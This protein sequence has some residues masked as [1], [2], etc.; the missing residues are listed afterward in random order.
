MDARVDELQ[1]ILLTA[2]K[3]GLEEGFKLYYGIYRGQV[4]DNRDPQDMGRVQVRVDDLGQ[5]DAS[6]VWLW[7]L[8]PLAGSGKGSFFPPDLGDW[9]FVVFSQGNQSQPFAYFGGWFG[10]GEL[11]TAL[12]PGE[13]HTPYRRGFVSRFG[14]GFVFSDEPDNEYVRLTWN[15]PGASDPA[16]EDRTLS[17]VEGEGKTS[18][19]EFTKD[20]G[21]QIVVDSGG[22]VF[23]YT[24]A[25]DGEKARFLLWE[26]AN[27]NMLEMNEDGISMFDKAGNN[28]NLSKGKFTVVAEK[29]IS[30]SGKSVNFACSGVGLGFPAPM[31][32][33]LGEPL[34]AWLATHTH[35]TAVG[36]SLPPTI[37]P[38]P[39]LL[40]QSVK[41]KP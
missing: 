10:E 27:G 39:T 3:H 38:T 26:T 4:T 7:P 19:L 25:K 13:D 34:L 17:A 22:M 35:G 32:A 6:D 24:P 20:G 33:V 36:P 8:F 18:I 9:V 29:G 1:D 30:L 37:P 21:L 14:H 12:T 16:R 28:V 41:L 15:K 40:S 5:P 11:P 2:L 23:D 31:S